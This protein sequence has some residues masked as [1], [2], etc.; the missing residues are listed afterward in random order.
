MLVMSTHL[1]P[2]MPIL[3]SRN[4]ILELLAVMIKDRF[5]ITI[6]HIH[7]RLLRSQIKLNRHLSFLKKLNK[8]QM[9]CKIPEH[10]HKQRASTLLGF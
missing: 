9:P 8:P 10:R 5:M 1:S 3:K 6:T 2:P 7:P 4:L